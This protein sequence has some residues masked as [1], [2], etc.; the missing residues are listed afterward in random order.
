MAYFPRSGGSGGGI[1]QITS[2]GATVTVTNPFGPVTDLETSGAVT[3]VTAAN[4]TMVVT[5][6]SGAVTVSRGPL[7]GDV[8]AAA[9]SSSSTVTQINGAPL[10]T[11]TGASTNQALM[12]NGSAYVPTSITSSMVTGVQAGPLT[13]DVTTSGTAATLV[14]TTNV[15]NI[16]EGIPL[17]NFTPTAAVNMHGQT[18]TNFAYIGWISDGT[19]W[20]R[21]SNTTFTVP[22]NVT[23]TYP[24][25]TIVKWTESSTQKY[26]IV[27]SSAFTT[28][29]TVTLVTTSDYIMAATPD[30]SSNQYAQSWLSI[31][32]DFPSSFTWSGA[33]QTGGTTPALSATF[34]IKPGR[35]ILLNWNGALGT[36]N[37]VSYT[38]TGMP[39]PAASTCT[40]YTGMSAMNNTVV[41][42]GGCAQIIGA[43]SVLT[44]SIITALGLSTNGWTSSGTKAAA[45]QIEYGY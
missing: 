24:V 20:T 45:G 39:I 19:V 28:L 36:S 38:I 17:Q 11:T 42:A 21:T 41:I 15:I 25:G 14:G 5:P 26:G 16:I 27:L 29:T 44:F 6:T 2:T 32:S 43:V 37:A 7:S 18:I 22:G 34:S 10:G 12:W 3:S 4:G 8:T 30:A 40:V 13:G 1:S 35:R 33:A 9:G 23:A 31:P